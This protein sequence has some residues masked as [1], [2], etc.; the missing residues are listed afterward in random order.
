MSTKHKPL[1]TLQDIPWDRF[2]P[3]QV[4]ADILKVMKTASLVEYNATDYG[5]YLER[6]FEGDA[7][8]RPAIRDWVQEEIQH[9]QAL[10]Q[11]AER[12]DPSFD[13]H[14]S[15]KRFHENF[16]LPL[17]ATQSVRGSCAGELL[18]RCI[19][20][21]GTSSFYTAL[22]EASTEP[23]LSYI[24]G[25]I[26]ADEFRHY[27]LFYTHLQRYAAKSPFPFYQRVYIAL[28]RLLES[29]DD[30][31]ASAYFAA[32]VPPQTSYKKVLFSQAYMGRVY[33][34]YQPHHVD[35]VMG[36]V[37]KAIGLNPQGFWVRPLQQLIWW[38]LT[39]RAKK[40]SR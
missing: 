27:K 34:Y 15:L 39:R 25:K 37:F 28:G 9:G 33:P 32:N 6:V 38:R 2:D 5:I 20:E 10:R 4:N 30:E 35:R 22:K 13:F 1:W 23:A 29:E 12:A 24:C 8:F 11:W 31:L 3:Q 26:A 18:A 19:V 16:R 17:T 21:T 40:F 36:M 14:T 7:L